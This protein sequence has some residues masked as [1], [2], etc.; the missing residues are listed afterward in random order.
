MPPPSVGGKRA[1]KRAEFR[2]VLLPDNP[3]M[4]T[5]ENGRG[6]NQKL[7]EPAANEAQIFDRLRTAGQLQELAEPGAYK[8]SNFKST[9]FDS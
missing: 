3:A 7:A 1:S 5:G 9:N 6:R 4:D 2:Q 8:R